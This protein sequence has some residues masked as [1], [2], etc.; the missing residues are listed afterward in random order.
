MFYPL[1]VMCE[2]SCEQCQK[3]GGTPSAT[4]MCW[5]LFVLSMRRC[6]FTFNLFSFDLVILTP[7]LP[8]L[9]FGERDGNDQGH[10]H[11]KCL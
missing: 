2:G 9:G 3:S 10:T 8:F 6:L 5:L 7:F 11:R 1:N 4:T